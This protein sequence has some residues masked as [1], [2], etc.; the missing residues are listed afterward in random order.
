MADTIKI[1]NLEIDNLKVGTLSVDA[2]YIGDV[3]IYPSTPTP[4][5]FDVDLNNQWVESTKTL[6]GY[7]VY[8][9]NSNQYVDN[10]YASMKFKF[11]GQP[12]FKIWINSYAESSYDYTIAWNMDV[13]YPTSN[14]DFNSTGVKG[15]T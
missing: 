8:M 11:K 7:K 14:P 1:G 15:H 6:D 3:K 2:L 13:D 5:V 4:T 12:D 9:S 10:G